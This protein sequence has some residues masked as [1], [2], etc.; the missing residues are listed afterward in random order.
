ML[1]WLNA[2]AK[3]VTALIAA[4]GVLIVVGAYKATVDDLK[5]RVTRL[6]RQSRAVAPDPR[7]A[8]C[9]RIARETYGD[10]TVRSVN[11]NAN[12]L[13]ARLGCDARR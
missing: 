1:K 9:A 6:E 12:A 8:E 4:A 2:N 5:D 3:A 13:L 7:A 11:E 10:G